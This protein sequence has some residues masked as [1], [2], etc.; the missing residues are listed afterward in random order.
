MY[1]FKSH[2]RIKNKIYSEIKGI[3]EDGEALI[4]QNE[5]KIENLELKLKLIK[6]ENEL[7]SEKIFLLKKTL[8][9][10]NNCDNDFLKR[11]YRCFFTKTD[12]EDD[13]SS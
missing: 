12:I 8:K 6:K 11:C 10:L 7:T 3:I 1:K 2:W 4:S 5:E 13:L 9:K